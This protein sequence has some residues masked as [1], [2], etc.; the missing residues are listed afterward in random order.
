VVGLYEPSLRECI[1]QRHG[2]FFVS[3]SLP[4]LLDRV[5]VVDIETSSLNPDD[6]EMISYGVAF[7][8]T[9]LIV[10]RLFGSDR[11]L[12]RL[13][14]T[15]LGILIKRGYNVYAWYKDFEE[16][17][18]KI[19]C[20]KELQIMRYEKKDSSLSWGIPI[21]ANNKDIPN[22]WERW[23]R[24]RDIRS[25]LKIV[26]RNLYCVLI[27]ASSILRKIYLEARKKILF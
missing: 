27:E 1:D 25:V 5:A 20:L 3:V 26:E 10:I 23:K 22:Y 2:F 15:H 17:W 14:R 18:L 11:L 6:G 4:F 21:P 9:A 8:N 13:A 19:Y 7:D 16:K 12:R 24:Y